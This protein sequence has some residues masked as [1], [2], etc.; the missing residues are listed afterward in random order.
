MLHY[1]QGA[2][3]FTGCFSR[4]IQG[5]SLFIGC[6]IKWCGVHYLQGAALHTG[7]ALL[8]VG[9]YLQGSITYRLLHYIQEGALLILA[10][11]FLLCCCII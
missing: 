3:L 2:N 9:H 5:A 1:I 11:V 7:S 4:Y 6:F 8:A 10:D